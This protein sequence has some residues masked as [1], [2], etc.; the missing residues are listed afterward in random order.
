MQILGFCM[1]QIG[2]SPPRTRGS[3]EQRSFLQPSLWLGWEAPWSLHLGIWS[4]AVTLAK[5]KERAL[6]IRMRNRYVLAGI[7]LVP[8]PPVSSAKSRWSYKDVADHALHFL[9]PDLQRPVQDGVKGVGS[10]CCH[11]TQSTPL[12]QYI[13]EVLLATL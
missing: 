2:S 6:K 11:T 12:C 8:S 5:R 3:A 13:K 1:G 7:L 4:R 9:S 10:L